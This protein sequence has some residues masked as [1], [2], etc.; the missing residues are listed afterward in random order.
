MHVV[1]FIDSDSYEELLHKIEQLGEKLSTIAGD[2]T[3]QKKWLTN[4][5]VCEIL[6]VTAKTLQNYRDK[7]VIAFSKI[8]SKIYYKQSDL[9]AL[10]DAHFHETFSLERRVNL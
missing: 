5:E 7:G 3:G 8:G 4:K 10:L 1:K 6:S 2:K 9:N